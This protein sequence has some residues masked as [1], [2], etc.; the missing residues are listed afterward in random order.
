VETDGLN[1][2]F[3]EVDVAAEGTL[4]RVLEVVPAP[5]LVEKPRMSLTYERYERPQ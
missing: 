4:D 1:A 5:T 2:G 3:Y